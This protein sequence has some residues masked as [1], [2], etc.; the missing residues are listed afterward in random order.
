M[1]LIRHTGWPRARRNIWKY[2]NA[3][4]V[5][6][7]CSLENNYAETL[8]SGRI[9]SFIDKGGTAWTQALSGILEQIVRIV[10]VVIPLFFL[11]AQQSFLI[12]IISGGVVIFG[13]GIVF[14]LNKKLETYKRQRVQAVS[15]YD[16]RL[17]RSVQSRFDIVQNLAI[18]DEIE[19]LHTHAD[20]YGK[21]LILQV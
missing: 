8:G 20:A 2:F 12:A 9:F 13:G 1:F 5:P 15:E 6:L 16:R 4:Y 21:P 11:L 18:Q 10:V 17:L 14:F 19:I 7:V 3:H